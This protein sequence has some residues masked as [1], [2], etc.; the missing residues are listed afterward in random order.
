MT[1]LSVCRQVA[2]VIGLD[3]PTAVA[4]S[5][6][7]EHVELMT[8]ANEMAQRIAFDTR[9]WTRLKTLATFTGDGSDTTFDLPSDYRRMVKKARLWSSATPYT[10][11]IHYPDTDA[12]LGLE[13]QNFSSIVGRWTIIGT[14]FLIKPAIAAAAT[15][16]FYYITNKIITDNAVSPAYKTEFTVDADGFLMDERVLKLGMIWQWKANKGLPYGEDMATYEEALSNMAGADKGTNVL[17]VG[18]ARWPVGVDMAFPGVLG[19]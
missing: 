6:D 13:E 10:T 4:A 17:V 7:R 14:Q 12:W 9:D 18:Q 8:V 2:A 5:T 11:L 19:P 15:V 3:V 16:K 1:L